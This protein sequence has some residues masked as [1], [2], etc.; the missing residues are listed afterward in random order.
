MSETMQVTATL[1]PVAKELHVK[2]GEHVMVVGGVVVGVYS[3]KMLRTTPLLSAPTQV[4]APSK[5]TP[6]PIKA[7]APTAKK[8]GG[9]TTAR[10][11]K[12]R[13]T[14][15]KKILS[16]VQKTP[17]IESKEL[18]DAAGYAR[19]APTRWHVHDEVRF[20]IRKGNIR[21]EEVKPGHPKLGL[22]HFPAPQETAAES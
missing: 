17:G 22:R 12:D 1:F 21:T 20:L 14:L 9:A 19:N 10:S 5:P 8:R 7:A 11:E 2:P 3:G 16:V 13:E 6:L 4:A 15:R 18:G